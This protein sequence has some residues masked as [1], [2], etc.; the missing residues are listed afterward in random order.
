MPKLYFTH[1]KRRRTGKKKEEENPPEKR[2]REDEEAKAG[3]S[4]ATEETFR[5]APRQLPM[6]KVLNDLME[7][8][9]AKAQRDLHLEFHRRANEILDAEKAESTCRP[10]AVTPDDEDEA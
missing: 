9:S 1:R 2:S 3:T 5:I 6:L 7:Q 8:L 4:T 10:E